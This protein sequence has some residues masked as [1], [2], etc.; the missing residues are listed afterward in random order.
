MSGIKVGKGDQALYLELGNDGGIPFISLSDSPNEG[1]AVE[2]MIE[3]DQVDEL[4]NALRTLQA[5]A[6]GSK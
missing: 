6:G 4:V 5:Q 3:L 1:E 2:I